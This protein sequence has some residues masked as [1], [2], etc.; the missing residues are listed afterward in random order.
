MEN[1]KLTPTDDLHDFVAQLLMRLGLPFPGG[2]EERMRL[3]AL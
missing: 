3:V 2:K 1:A